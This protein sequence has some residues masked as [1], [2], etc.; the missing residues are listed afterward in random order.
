M[1]SYADYSNIVDWNGRLGDFADTAHVVS[2]LDLVISVDTG[3][4]HLA[5]ALGVPTWLML[6]YDA[7]FRWLRNCESS[8]WYPNMKLFRQASYGDWS[9]VTHSILAEIGFVYG[10]DLLS[11]V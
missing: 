9:S 10:L 6:H 7:D 11:L 3:V 8:P 4:A 5:G 2:Q 1:K